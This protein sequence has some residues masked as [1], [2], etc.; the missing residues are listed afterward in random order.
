[1]S[2][3]YHRFHYGAI[4]LCPGSPFMAHKTT[5][6]DGTIIVSFFLILLPLSPVRVAGPKTT[7]P[8][9]GHTV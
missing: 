3:D 2:M 5:S 9:I 6:T 8:T 1:M 7:H 4:T